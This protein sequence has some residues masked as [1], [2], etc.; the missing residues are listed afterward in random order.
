MVWRLPENGSD[1]NLESDTGFGGP[2]PKER[3]ASDV[4]HRPFATINA[5]HVCNA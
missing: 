4:W 1:S 2:R 5:I 3:M